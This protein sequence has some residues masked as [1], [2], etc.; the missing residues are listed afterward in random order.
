MCFFHKMV[1][2]NLSV[3]SMAAQYRVSPSVVN[4]KYSLRK[5]LRLLQS[6]IFLK[7]RIVVFSWNLSTVCRYE[8]NNRCSSLW[9]KLQL[10]GVIFLFHLVR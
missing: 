10:T 5:R 6:Q 1:S 4:L 2:A 9:K 3:Q 7:P 8:L